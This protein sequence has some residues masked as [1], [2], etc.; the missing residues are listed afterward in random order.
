MG[1]HLGGERA[2]PDGGGRSWSVRSARRWRRRPRKGARADWGASSR[3]AGPQDGRRWTARAIYEAGARR[4]PA[5]GMAPRSRLALSTASTSPSVHVG[6]SRA[7]VYRDGPPPAHRG[8]LVDPGAGA[9][10][11]AL[12]RRCA[13]CR[14]S[15]TSS[16]LGGLRADRRA[17]LSRC[18]SRPGTATCCARTGSPTTSA[19]E[20][21]NA[22]R[23]STPTSA[24]PGEMA[25]DRAGDD[26]ITCVVIYVANE[27][28]SPPRAVA[29][30]P[31]LAPKFRR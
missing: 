17:D 14:A 7:Y 29:L 23:R 26:N 19:E 25:N 3:G 30:H 16:P 21:G 12:P 10:G 6:D 1:G 2:E 13:W 4:R 20:I 24:R 11:A 5:L 9:R 27:G 8:P 18:R 31:P 28:R 22:D 15:V